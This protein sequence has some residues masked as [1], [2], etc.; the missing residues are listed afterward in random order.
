MHIVLHGMDAS[1]RD[2]ALLVMNYSED[3][4]VTHRRGLPSS[5]MLRHFRGTR[6][7]RVST[8]AVPSGKEKI[9]TRCTS[10]GLQSTTSF[11]DCGLI[12]LA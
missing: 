1:R 8:D 12:T 5:G 6:R 11:V 10:H 9:C 3:V 2:A 4:N 7:R